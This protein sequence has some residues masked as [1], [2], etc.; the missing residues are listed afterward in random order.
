MKPLPILA[1]PRACPEKDCARQGEILP[2]VVPS[3]VCDALTSLVTTEGLTLFQV[4]LSGFAA[5]FHGYTTQTDILIGTFSPSGR[6]HTQTANLLGYFLNPVALRY[7][8]VG[9]PSFREL[10]LQTRRILSEA[11]A[12][13]DIPMDDLVRQLQ[14]DEARGPLVRVAISLQPRVPRLRSSWNVTTMDARTG[15]SFWDFYLA[16][17]EGDDGLK[18]RAQFN[19]AFLDEKTILTTLAD[20]WKLLETASLRP[21]L[22]AKEL[23]S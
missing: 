9:D 14:L 5:L 11:I 12:N 16:F 7:S 18:G 23:L 21:E 4:L 20:L 19:P 10:S 6:K 1:W 22:S 17:I 8:F 15:G 3:S 2:F 13:D